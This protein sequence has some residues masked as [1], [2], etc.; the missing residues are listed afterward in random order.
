M[1]P[2]SLPATSSRLATVRL[3]KTCTR[4][5]IGMG[6]VVAQGLL[7]ALSA[8]AD[9]A[10]ALFFSALRSPAEA[11]ATLADGLYLFGQA[12]QSDQ[13]GSTYLVFAIEDRRAVGAFYRPA[14]SFD[15]FYGQV[16]AD[17]LS[18]TVVNSYDQSEHPYAIATQTAEPLVAGTVGTTVGLVGF[19]PITEL[20]EQD[21]QILNTCQADY[22]STI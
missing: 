22:T 19:H 8:A 20:S 17:A 1:Y 4:L 3:V 2:F 7:P 9:P 15:C 16:E 13:I 10:S 12:S 14:S 5:A 6:L 18:L 11:A 21:H